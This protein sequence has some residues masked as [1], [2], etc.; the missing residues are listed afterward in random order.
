MSVSRG[1]GSTQLAKLWVQR[2]TLSS[3]LS[4]LLITTVKRISQ[5][6]L[7]ILSI[8]ETRLSI[9]RNYD[10]L[11]FASCSKIKTKICDRTMLI[12]FTVVRRYNTKSSRN[13]AQDLKIRFLKMVVWWSVFSF[14]MMLVIVFL[15]LSET[16]FSN[17]SLHIQIRWRGGYQHYW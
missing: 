9:T 15:S 4:D 6:L 2:H 17:E 11:I 12:F 3:Y 8:L 7:E 1:W 16:W 5:G 13:I 14:Y 10:C